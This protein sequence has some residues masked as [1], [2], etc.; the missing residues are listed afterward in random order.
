MTDARHEAPQPIRALRKGGDIRPRLIEACR[1]LVKIK[2]KDL[3]SEVWHD[4]EWLN[5][6][7]DKLSKNRICIKV[8]QRL[9]HKTPAQMSEG[10]HRIVT[11]PD[12]LRAYQPTMPPARQKHRACPTILEM[13]RQA[14]LDS[15]TYVDCTQRRLF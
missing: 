13:K 5:G 10:V 9:I 6:S 4:H 3:P 2:G 14:D 12:A 1:A 8:R 15:G 7:K 11:L